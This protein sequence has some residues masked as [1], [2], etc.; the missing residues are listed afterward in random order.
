[1][2]LAREF[3]KSDAQQFGMF[4]GTMFET[5]KKT[6]AALH[7]PYE[8]N[9]LSS[10]V[11]DAN[12]PSLGINQYI[13]R[14]NPTEPMIPAELMIPAGS[15]FESLRKAAQLLDAVKATEKP[16]ADPVVRRE[17]AESLKTFLTDTVIP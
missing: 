9:F 3:V 2:D 11:P 1:M 8:D 6:A 14:T 15:G 17:A 4:V 12:F 7:E 16:G 10:R 13:H 5:V